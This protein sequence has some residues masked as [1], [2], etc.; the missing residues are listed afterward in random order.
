MRTAKPINET[1][2]FDAPEIEIANIVVAARGFEFVDHC[3]RY[4]PYRSEF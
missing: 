2:E 3:A 1:L 4:H